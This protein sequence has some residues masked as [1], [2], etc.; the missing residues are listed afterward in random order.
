M[1][2]HDRAPVAVQE[3]MAV[4][5]IAN[6]LAGLCSHELFILPALQ[7][8][9]YCALYVPWAR[10]ED[11]ALAD[12]KVGGSLQAVLSGP[13]V[14]GFEQDSMRLQ[15]ILVRETLDRGEA[16]AAS[17]PVVNDVCSRRRTISRS[18]SLAR[19]RRY[20]RVSKSPNG[21]NVTTWIRADISLAD[22]PSL[23]G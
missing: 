4:G 2:H 1:H 22:V 16:Q 17:M 11:G 20:P 5:K 7:R 8:P 14:D 21:S 18:F 9:I 12:R 19:L 3:W 15:Y 13:G 10:E 23:S 6:D